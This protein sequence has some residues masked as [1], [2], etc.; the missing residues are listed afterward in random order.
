[1]MS[2]KDGVGQIIKTCVTVVTCIA[3]T[4]WFRVI[5]ATLNNLLR[6]TRGTHNAVGPAQLTN[7]PITLHLVDEILDVDLHGR[8]PVRDSGMRC[9]QY[10][11][12]SHATTL[13]S[14][15]IVRDNARRSDCIAVVGLLTVY[16]VRHITSSSSWRPASVDTAHGAKLPENPVTIALSEQ[17]GVC[18]HGEA[19]S[20][21]PYYKMR[22]ARPALCSDLLAG[23]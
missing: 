10:T 5:K 16:H 1:M 20:K 17:N 14:N 6:L 7:R 21:N 13:E 12:S 2:S 4:S 23:A 15:K 18:I 8:T 22:P 9:R 11:S 3:S 19:L